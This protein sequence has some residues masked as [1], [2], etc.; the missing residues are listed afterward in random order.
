MG[1]IDKAKQE[2]RDLV[3]KGKRY[4][5]IGR[6]IVRKLTGFSEAKKIHQIVRNRT[7]G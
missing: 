2:E 4:Y 5:K 3:N 7:M 1:I 6:H